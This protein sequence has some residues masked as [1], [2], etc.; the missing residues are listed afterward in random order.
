MKET[1]LKMF[2]FRHAC[3]VFDPNRRVSDEDFAFILEAARLS[4]SS[5]GFEPWKLLIVE[6]PVLRERI[7]AHTWGGRKQISTC[8]RL[9]AVLARKAYYMR[10][11]SPYV[12][13]IMRDIKGLDEEGQAVHRGLFESFQ[14][15]DFELHGNERAMFDWACKQTYLMMS[16]MMLAAAAVGVDS[17]PFEGFHRDDIENILARDFGVD[18]GRFGISFMIAFGYRVDEPPEKTRQHIE[19]IVEWF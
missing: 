15:R 8:S 9:A 19:E 6:K 1:M 14:K 10:Y 4:P 11:D 13:N 7:K 3:K 5:F 2:R 18:T 12:S 17:C 16:Q